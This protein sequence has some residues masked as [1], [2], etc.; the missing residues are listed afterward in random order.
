[1]SMQQILATFQGALTD[2]DIGLSAQLATLANGDTRIRTDF[3]FVEAGAPENAM[4]DARKPNVTTQS[5]R[6]MATSKA[7]DTGHRD[8]DAQVDVLYEF[9]GSDREIMELNRAN[10][11]TALAM[12]VDQLRQYSDQHDGTIIE[13]VDPI[14]YEFGT[15]PGATSSG[16][17]ATITLSERSKQ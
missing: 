10:A 11:A 13:T 6:W 4:M 5:R 15:F 12:V 16:F 17:R 3:T 7:S 14:N 8:A 9:F 2:D 1:M